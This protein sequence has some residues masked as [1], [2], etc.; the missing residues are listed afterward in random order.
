VIQGAEPQD[1][2][3][4]GVDADGALLVDIDGDRRRIVAGEVSIR[5]VR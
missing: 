1:G 5:P 2:Y 3:A 4:R